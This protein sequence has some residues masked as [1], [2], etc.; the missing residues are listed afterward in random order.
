[1]SSS[2][3]LHWFLLP[4]TLCG[5]LI[6][7]DVVNWLRGR[8]DTFDPVGILGLLGFYFFFLAPLLHLSMNY[9]LDYVSYPHDWRDWLGGMAGLNAL[10][11]M[12]YQ[13]SRYFFGLSWPKR[14]PFRKVSW[15]IDWSRFKV[16]ITLALIF[17]ALLQSWVYA[18]FGGIS[19]YIALSTDPNS[20]VDQ[21][22]QNWGWIFMISESF[23]I[24]AMMT[25][26][27]YNRRKGISISWITIGPVL[28]IFFALLIY[29]GG[30]RGSRANTVWGLFWGVG[31]IHFWIKPITKKVI[32]VGCIFLVLFMYFYGFFK[33]AGLNGLNAFTDEAARAELE[34]KTD[35]D[36]NATLLS[37]LER[38]D[39]QAFMLYRISL[40]DS[41]YSYAWGR[42]YVAAVSILIPRSIFPDRP[43]LKV[44]EGTE[45]LFGKNTYEPGIFD[46][47]KVYGLAGEAMLNFGPLAVPPIFLVLALV[48]AQVRRL[49]FRWRNGDSRSLLL[50]LLVNMCFVILVNDLDNDI[51]NFI[52]GSSVPL[53]ILILTSNRHNY[54]SG[55]SSC[56]LAE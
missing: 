37:D 43:P 14:P 25:F 23:P 41:D 24:L 31:I 38:S 26:A 7:I 29:F 18:Q 50:P 6:G 5:V 16:I 9:W 49:I 13:V 44:K 47:S 10:G 54:Q 46:S 35:R 17:T 28:L 19:G 2:Q 39:V 36:L 15:E 55:T 11:L 48:V 45:L 56:S 40:P 20:Y 3:F 22:M 4:V 51:F 53:L 12:V 52:K 27:V 33:G 8:L 21:P 42:T 32:G 30:L 34:Q 1:M